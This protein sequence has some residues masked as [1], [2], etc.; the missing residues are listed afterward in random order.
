[1]RATEFIVE[2]LVEGSLNEYRDQLWTWVQSKFPRTQWPEY[3]QRDFLYA[4]A[5]GNKNQ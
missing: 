1:M 4:K 5:K 3:V 2:G